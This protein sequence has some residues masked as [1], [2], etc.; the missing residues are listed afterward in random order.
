MKTI[1]KNVFETNSSSVHAICISSEKETINVP[2]NI[3]VQ[4]GEFGWEFDKLSTYYEKLSYLYT[5]LCCFNDI[6]KIEVLKEYFNVENIDVE[7]E[8]PKYDDYLQNGYIDHYDELG[9]FINF[10][11]SDK[12][13]LFN[14]L[15]SNKS[16]I[17]TGND[18]ADREIKVREKY[19]HKVFRKG[20]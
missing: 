18:N 3:N 8:S 1:R 5:G 7:Y 13:I 6:E 10:V 4:I 9:D 16:Y 14:F 15:F 17:L 19:K 20:N 2:K 11:M 12:E